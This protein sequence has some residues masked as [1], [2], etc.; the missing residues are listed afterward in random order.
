MVRFPPFRY[1]LSAFL[2]GAASLPSM[3]ALAVGSLLTLSA[4]AQV[5]TAPV[6]NAPRPSSPQV[7]QDISRNAS[8]PVD[9]PSLA[10]DSPG[11]VAGDVS[12]YT[13]VDLALRNSSKVRAAEAGVQV[14]HGAWKETHDAYI[15][16]FALGSGLGYSYGFPLG[17]PTLF[18][19][20]SQSLLFSFSQPDYIRSA[21]AAEKAAALTLKNIRQQ[22]ILDA[23][24]D[25]VDLA[26]TLEQI[27]ALDQATADTNKLL[28]IMQSRLQ[29][30]LETDMQMT[31]ARLTGAQIDLRKIQMEN[32]ADELRQHLSN[33]TG[34]DPALI[35]PESSSIPPLPNLNFPSLLQGSPLPPAVLA[36]DATA[37]SKL[38]AAWGD[39][40]QNHRPTV[41]FAAQYALFS[42]FNNYQE[43]YGNHFQYNNLGIG[44]QAVWPLFDRTRSD[45]ALESEA[46]AIRARRQAELARI[47]NSEGNLA[48]WHNLR[49]LEA[50][51]KVA[52]LQQQLARDT[53]AV[54]VTQ[55]NR[56]GATGPV[57]PQQTERQRIDE[58]TSY[59]GLQDAQFNVTKLKLDL[60]NAVGG[61]E[62]WA[63]GGTQVGSGTNAQHALQSQTEPR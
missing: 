12:L 4:G 36:A 18:N 11:A 9:S 55:M 49:V 63:K 33:M 14:A 28:V 20:T 8:S 48:L 61:L 44:I 38:F 46:E 1:L 42:T 45:K 7:Q 37:D 52:G 62:D 25:Y 19:V 47:Q 3:R 26:K 24:L 32:H 29:A 51:E 40:K 27:A 23:A 22:V 2:N 13:V 16:N 53:L 41:E 17:T 56:G 43:Y 31:R 39:R 15:P 57:A 30:G 10:A 50:Q 60:L 5:L 34:V 6:P 54:T 35:Q 58:R 21:R 59:V